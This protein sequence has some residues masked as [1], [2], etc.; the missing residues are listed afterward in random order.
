MA[1]TGHGDHGKHHIQPLWEADDKQSA[2]YARVYDNGHIDIVG[3]NVRLDISQGARTARAPRS[4]GRTATTG[5]LTVSR[6]TR[7]R[8]TRRRSSHPRGSRASPLRSRP[9][10]KGWPALCCS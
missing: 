3:R 6:G 9:R 4:G 7:R 10:C 2:I 8:P 5:T 1:K